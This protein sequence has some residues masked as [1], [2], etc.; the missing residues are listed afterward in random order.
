MH[1][2]QRALSGMLKGAREREGR[3]AHERTSR[4][5]EFE[6]G[7]KRERK[8]EIGSC[9]HSAVGLF[10]TAS[11]TPRLF[12]NGSREM[13]LLPLRGNIPFFFLNEEEINKRKQNHGVESRWE[14]SGR[15][16]RK[17]GVREESWRESVVNGI[18]LGGAPSC[19]DKGPLFGASEKRI[20][21]RRGAAFEQGRI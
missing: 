17:N 13:P 12:E 7:R 14:E 4:G 1:R 8:K 6:E 19:S 15:K 9:V 16:R 21:G 10:F 18:I 5:R 20:G 3:C 2:S 11:K